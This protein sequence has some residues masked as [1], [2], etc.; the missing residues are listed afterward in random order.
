MY[1]SFKIVKP[2]MNP[3]EKL[4]CRNFTSNNDVWKHTI[5]NSF[6]MENFP[7]HSYEYM[8]SNMNQISPLKKRLIAETMQAAK[9]N[10]N[11]LTPID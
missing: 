4:V 3:T 9:G 5:K 6:K 7:P 2:L 8:I 11:M 10:E 1:K